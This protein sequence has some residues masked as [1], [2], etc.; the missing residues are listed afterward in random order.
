MSLSNGAISTFISQPEAWM[1]RIW[2]T[3]RCQLHLESVQ[4]QLVDYFCQ[5]NVA[6]RAID[7]TI[8]C[9]NSWGRQL[10][11]LL[12][13]PKSVGLFVDRSQNQ[14][15]GQFILWSL[16]LSPVQSSLR[17]WY[18]LSLFSTFPH[19]LCCSLQPLMS[20]VFGNK[21]HCHSA[22]DYYINCIYTKESLLSRIKSAERG[23]IAI[24]SPITVFLHFFELLS[25]VPGGNKWFD[26][27]V[28]LF[29]YMQKGKHIIRMR[30]VI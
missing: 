9:L 26:E 30:A 11:L 1:R 12:L 2:C 6:A 27:S 24:F 25:I 3:E 29:Y 5:G 7:D 13:G 15:F 21:F 16:F 17:S 4:N 18:F 23:T 22:F 28:Y 19:S 20:Y 8:I 14:I 10:H